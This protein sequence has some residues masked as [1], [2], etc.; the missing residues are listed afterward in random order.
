MWGELRIPY[1]RS[2]QKKS[3][4]KSSTKRTSLVLH[5]YYCQ[6]R[7]LSTRHLVYLLNGQPARGLRR[8]SCNR[9]VHF[10]EKPH[11]FVLQQLNLEKSE[12]ATLWLAV[13][14]VAQPV[15]CPELRS[16]KR[17]AQWGQ[18]KFNSRLRHRSFGNNSRQA[19]CVSVRQKNVGSYKYADGTSS[20]K[21]IIY[22]VITVVRGCIPFIE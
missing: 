14:A 21:T 13:A 12:I 16:H 8:W 5:G 1:S 6:S 9:L 4:C 2:I 11:V 17:E 18:R 7:I 20:R 15:K 22:S 10:T 3:L 19:I